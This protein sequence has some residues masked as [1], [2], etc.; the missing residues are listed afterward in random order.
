MNKKHF[1]SLF[2]LF[3]SYYKLYSVEFEKDILTSNV[4]QF[5]LK[6]FFRKKVFLIFSL[7]K[8]KVNIY[9]L[10]KTSS[11]VEEMSRLV[12]CCVFDQL[13]G[14]DQINKFPAKID[15]TLILKYSG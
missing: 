13:I 11:H 9:E 12:D 14:L 10:F 15:A 3:E 5:L 8:S 6:V 2:L 7:K 4:H 1:E